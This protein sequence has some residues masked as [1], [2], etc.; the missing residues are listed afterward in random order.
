MRSSR[1]HS[2]HAIPA[3]QIDLIWTSQLEVIDRPA[4]GQAALR[5][6][7]PRLSP[8]SVTSRRTTVIAAVNGNYLEP[9]SQPILAV[10]R[11]LPALVA[12]SGARWPVT[13]RGQEVQD[14]PSPANRTG[15]LTDTAHPATVSSTCGRRGRARPG[16][17]GRFGA[18][19]GR[20]RRLV[21][22]AESG[23][24][25]GGGTVTSPARK[26][27]AIAF[28]SAWCRVPSIRSPG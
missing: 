22:L 13:Q 15:A 10:L 1:R 7:D 4:A 18:Y 26:M 27:I 3:R 16:G 21:V 6:A 8:R 28:T 2:R 5:T 9:V 19:L 12:V 23:R 25:A 14:L 20:A 11:G 17:P 24:Q